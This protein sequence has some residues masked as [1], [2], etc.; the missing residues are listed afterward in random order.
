MDKEMKQIFKNNL[1]KLIIGLVLL[2]FCYLYVQKYPAEKI[3]IFSGFDVMIQRA[4]I[5]LNKF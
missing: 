5:L 3:A 4:E 2:F 1:I